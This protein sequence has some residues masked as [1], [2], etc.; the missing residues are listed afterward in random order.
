MP[1]A[2]LIKKMEGVL[3]VSILSNDLSMNCSLLKVWLNFELKHLA[4][5]LFVLVVI[6]E[7]FN[8]HFTRG[9]RLLQFFI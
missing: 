5:D 9:Y 6:W 2:C 7:T 4:L 3:C 1:V 8:Y